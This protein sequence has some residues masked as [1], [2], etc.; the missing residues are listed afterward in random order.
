MEPG[1]P[2]PMDLEVSEDELYLLKQEVLDQLRT[3]LVENVDPQAH[4]PYLKSK[5]VLGEGDCDE[6]NAQVTRIAKADRFVDIIARRGPKA[7]DELCRSLHRN[8]TQMFLLKAMNCKLE[9][10]RQGYV[11]RRENLQRMPYVN[12]QL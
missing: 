6:I 2:A 1:P 5:N 11:Q 7:Y 3:R 9:K 10:L 4:F 12:N 8:G